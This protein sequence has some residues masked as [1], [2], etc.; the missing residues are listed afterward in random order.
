MARPTKQSH[1]KRQER[2]NLRLTVAEIEHLRAQALA[3]GL[4]PHEYARRRVLGFQVSPAPRQAD[5]ALVSEINRVGVNVNQLAR[6]Q[7]AEREF[8]GDWRA[9]R[10][11]L[12]RVL[13][14]VATRYGA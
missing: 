5:A 1:E 10:V 9:V 11:E 4:A 2:F 6:A 13:E 7:N 12:Q 3:A 8:R 14:K